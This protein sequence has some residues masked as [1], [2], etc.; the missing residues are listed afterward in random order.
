MRPLKLV[1]AVIATV[2]LTSWALGTA[3]HAAPPLLDAASHPKFE[4]A[5]PIPA[6]LDATGGGHFEMEMDE[7]VQWLGLVDHRDRPLMT[8][9]WGYGPVGAGVTYPGPTFVAR[10][11]RRITV[12]WNNRLPDYNFPRG[13]RA[14]LLPVD[15]NI[16]LAHPVEGGIPT[17]THL[18][19]GHTESAS[20]GLPEAWFTQGFAELGP[21]FVKPTYT[22]DND[23]EAAT[24]WYHDHALGITRLNVYAGLAGFYL[25]RDDREDRLVDRGVLPGGPYEIEIVVQDR[26]FTKQGELFYPSTDPE[27]EP[28]FPPLPRDPSAIAEFFG[29]FILVNGAAWPTLS[30]EPR[31][32]RF[33]FLNGSDSRFYVLEFRND[34]WNGDARSFLQIG[35]D[36]GLLHKPVGL[37][38]LLFAP[39]ERAD[40]LVDF[41][42]LSDG[43]E[44]FLRNFGADDPFKGF[45]ED[46]TIS[47]GEGGALDPADPMTTGQIMRFVVDRPFDETIPDATVDENTPLRPTISPLQQTGATRELVLFEGLDEYGRLQPLLG[48]LAEGSLAWFEP[49]TETPHLDDVEVWE[50]YNATEDAHPVHLHLV[51]FQIVERESFEGHVDE[52]PQPQ[53]DGSY[54]VGGTLTVDALGGDARGPEANEAGWKDTAVMFPGEVTRVIAKFDRE[55]RYVWHCH[56]LSHEDHEMMRPY[57]VV[58]DGRQLARV[59]A[60]G[61]GDLLSVATRG[62]EF[63]ITVGR[64]T[65]VEIRI[66]DVSGRQV[67]F[68]PSRAYPAGA[69]RVLWDG[70]N[71]AGRIVP[72]GVYFLRIA[73]PETARSARTVIVR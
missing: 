22:Y 27:I 49:I 37:T 45:N 56:I 32:Y 39:G 70:R 35:T 19:G 62:R 46:G 50:V 34:R 10:E 42:G 53:H 29:D 14:H 69:H 3:S 28:G 5:L 44:I 21:H 13:R 9:V 66:F 16:H 57:E 68:L 65:E 54:G 40:L 4:N 47:D 15:P 1:V 41:A 38:Q 11:D 71:G 25:L 6:R 59:T 72:S 61:P 33:R 30:V 8:T 2:I 20:D 58:A 26:M 73:T 36:V 18:H 43:T 12:T 55:G 31:K 63:G 60:A 17:V 67:R 24:L 7:T 51:A 48:T 52:K 23:Q 64:P